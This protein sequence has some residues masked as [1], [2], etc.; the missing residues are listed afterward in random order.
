M[1][2]QIRPTV[3][4]WPF[5]AGDALMLGLAWFVHWEA[6]TLDH[7]AITAVCVCVGLGA[8]LGILPFILDYRLSLKRA[9]AEGL[10]D[11]VSQIKNLEGI[12][13]QI[14]FA[15]SQWQAVQDSSA[16]TVAA[17]TEI[18]ERMATEA[19]AFAESMQRANDTEKSTLRLEAE[20]L[21]RS[22]NDWL[23]IVVVMLDH[24]YGLQSAAARSGKAAFAEPITQYQNAVRDVA[25]RVGLLPFAPAAG[26][27]FDEKRH[28]SNGDSKPEPG[29]RVAE[30]IATGYTFRGQ[31][32]RPALVK[33]AEP[34]ASA[35]EPGP[36]AQPKANEPT[37]L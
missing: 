12:A 11:A 20:K 19:K 22:E 6:R 23:Q 5:F 34:T 27:E 4:K 2:D 28:Q 25:R 24:T 14:S 18:G 10:N 16:K 15:T 36:E 29:A 32:I 21:R 35:D 17:A 1:T 9:E 8:L 30:T 13:G 26:D 37:L 7:F 31:L 3:P 33:I